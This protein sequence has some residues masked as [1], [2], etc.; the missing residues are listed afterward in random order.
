MEVLHGPGITFICRVNFGD[1]K[2]TIRSVVRHPAVSIDV[3][4]H[5]LISI[6]Y[7]LLL[8]CHG[9]GRGFE[10]RRPRHIL[11]H[12]EQLCNSWQDTSKDTD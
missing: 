2:G 12:L 10:S 9:R 1:V 6:S 8:P 7:T 4:R 11:K 5:R 3:R